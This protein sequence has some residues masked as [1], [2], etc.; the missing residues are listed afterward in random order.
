MATHPWRRGRKGFTLIELLVVIAIIGILAGMLLPALNRARE[1]GKAAACL[2]NMHQWAVALNLYNDDWGDYYPY[3]G[4]YTGGLIS[5]VDTWFDVLPPYMNQK[6]L[7]SLYNATPPTPPMAGKG[8]VWICPSARYSGPTPTRQVPYFTYAISVC[9]HDRNAVSGTKATLV[10]FRT[11]R[12]NSP[13]NTIIFCEEN[14]YQPTYGETRGDSLSSRSTDGTYD[15]STGRHS[16]GLNF[17]LGDGHCEWIRV[18]D[19]CRN[20]PNQQYAWDDSSNGATKGDW[21]NRTP[22]PYHWWFAPNIAQ[23]SN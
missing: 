14:D 21:C 18:S 2:S 22:P 16:G 1:K 17:V 19:F 8:S 12:M 13:A 10:G 7:S 4:D 3:D 6:T 9:L 11:S 15:E 20:C 23:E 5:G